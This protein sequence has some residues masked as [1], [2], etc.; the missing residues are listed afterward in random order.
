MVDDLI[1]GLTRQ[2]KEEVIE[3]YLTERRL[4][5]LQ[6]EDLEGQA[7]QTRLRALKAGTRLNRLAYMMIGPEMLRRL[8]EILGIPQPSFWSD[9]LERKFSR[10]VRFIR[11][12]ALTDRA[13]FRKLVLEAYSRFFAW[14]KKYRQAYENLDAECRAVNTNIVGFQKNFDLL[15]ILNFLKN[16]DTSA[17]EKKHFLGEN[18]T[19]EELTSVDQKLY[20]RP[21]AFQGLNVPE[22]ISLS[23]PEAMEELLGMLTEEIYRKYPKNVKRLML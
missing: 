9:C 4:V 7:E 8:V 14:M 3:N 21:I 20:L 18:F 2:V 19:A 5:G 17:M 15:T 22:P 13:K 10:R 1:S 12:R 11:V 23:E 6:I 16:L